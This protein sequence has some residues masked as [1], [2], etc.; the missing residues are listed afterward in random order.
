ME[1][2]KNLDSNLFRKSFFSVAIISEFLRS[3][4]PDFS[5]WTLVLKMNLLRTRRK[6]YKPGISSLKIKVEFKA[7]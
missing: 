2:P 4:H 6:G 1:C 5:G 3:D 7:T